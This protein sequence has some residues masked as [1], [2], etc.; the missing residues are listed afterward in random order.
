MD[1]RYTITSADDREAQ[2][3]YYSWLAPTS[4]ISRLATP[5]GLTALGLGVYAYFTHNRALA[6]SLFGCGLFLLV[7]VTLPQFLRIRLGTSKNLNCQC[8][9]DVGD[10]GITFGG[11]GDNRS[12]RW[13]EFRKYC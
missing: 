11:S 2:R 10:Y 7:K 6:F 13:T 8:Q 9:I 12:L 3:I 5:F 1:L 4:W